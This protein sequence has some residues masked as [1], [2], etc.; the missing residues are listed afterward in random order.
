MHSLNPGRKLLR[1]IIVMTCCGQDLFQ[2]SQC[3][4]QFSGAIQVY[5]LCVLAIYLCFGP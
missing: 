1:L 2:T 4:S 5:K 3:D